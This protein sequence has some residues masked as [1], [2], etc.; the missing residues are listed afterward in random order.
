MG[1][2]GKCI[3]EGNSKVAKICCG[4]VGDG[5]IGEQEEEVCGCV[6]ML[7]LKHVVRG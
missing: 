5:V 6:N 3:I 2:G 4:S 1:V 7:V